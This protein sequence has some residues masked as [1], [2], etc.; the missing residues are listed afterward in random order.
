MLFEPVDTLC[1][2]GGCD[3]ATPPPSHLCD[4]VTVVT[5]PALTVATTPLASG[6]EGSAAEGAGCDVITGEAGC[7]PPA[8]RRTWAEWAAVRPEGWW[9][10]VRVL[11]PPSGDKLEVESSKEESSKYLDFEFDKSITWILNLF[12]FVTNSKIGLK[13]V[14]LSS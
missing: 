13:K 10:Q 4:L 11:P 2:S 8:W 6:E 3:L 14:I 12:L 1:A 7:C 5:P 9:Q